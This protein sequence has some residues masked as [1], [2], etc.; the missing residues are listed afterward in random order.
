MQARFHGLV[1]LLLAAGSPARAQAPAE[2]AEDDGAPD[3]ADPI[4]D[5]P[6]APSAAAAP[7]PFSGRRAW[8]VDGPVRLTG[9]VDAAVFA[10]QVAGITGDGAVW[11]SADRG[12]T[13]TQVLRP[14]G[15]LLGEPDDEDVLLRVETRFEDELDV[16]DAID[17]DDVET[18]PDEATDGL[19]DAIDDARDV[20]EAAI[21]EIDAERRADATVAAGHFVAF[22]TTGALFVGRPDGLYTTDPTGTL[23]RVFAAPITALAAWNEHWVAGTPTGLHAS[24]DDTVRF[25]A[26]IVAVAAGPDGIVL[27][28][29]DEI[30]R[31]GD[32]T[33]WL[34]EATLDTPALALA[35]DPDTGRLLVGHADGISEVGDGLLGPP[36]SGSPEGAAEIVRVGPRHWVAVG[37]GGVVESLDDGRRWAVLEGGLIVRIGTGLSAF[38][39]VVWMAGPD[40]LLRLAP[41]AEAIAAVAVAPWISPDVLVDAAMARPGLS[42]PDAFRAQRWVASA[43]PRLTVDGR[44]QPGGGLDYDAGSGTER[45]SRADWMVQVLLHWEPQRSRVTGDEIEAVGFDGVVVEG[46]VYLEGEVEAMTSRLS[47]DAARYAQ[48]I[49][50]DVVRLHAAR[51]AAMRDREAL[52]DRP[53]RELVFHELRIREI[54][55]RLDALTAGAVSRFAAGQSVEE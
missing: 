1:F 8:R 35:R 28:T 43:L 46:D 26:P 30:W 17:P 9:F 2:P 36:L 21:D 31:S 55:A 23:L 4:P 42:V 24:F 18:D 39:G 16:G 27:A 51:Q 38:G 53:L 49:A 47:R 44:L 14:R 32:G 45:A 33:G 29:P 22:S 12:A 40:G 5:A 41:I 52:A 20:A 15:T 48:D 6:A 11:L 7:E 10:E 34:R 3:G 13:W 19:E 50:R 25:E 54:E 37:R